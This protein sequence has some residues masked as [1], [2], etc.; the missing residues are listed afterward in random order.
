MIQE[1]AH[2]SHSRI[3]NQTTLVKHVKM[4]FL[5]HYV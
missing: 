2:K 4:V 1:S 5:S 3:M